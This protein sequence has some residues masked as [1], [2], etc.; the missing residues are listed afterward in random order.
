MYTQV[1]IENAQPRHPRQQVQPS[2][3]NRRGKRFPPKRIPSK[4]WR[5]IPDTIA[6]EGSKASQAEASF[7]FLRYPVIHPNIS[8]TVISSSEKQ[9][10]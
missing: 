6:T 4:E 2:S 1:Y 10:R 5:D 7:N 9:K 3:L 8:V